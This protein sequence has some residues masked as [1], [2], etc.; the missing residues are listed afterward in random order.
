MPGLVVP[1]GRRAG[2][3]LLGAAMGTRKET[4]GE[5]LSGQL[6]PRCYHSFSREDRE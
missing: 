2:G 4:G 1:G 6:C 5:T 3:S